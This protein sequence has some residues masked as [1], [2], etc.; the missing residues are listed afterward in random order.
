M[1]T[2]VKLLLIGL[3]YQCTSLSAEAIRLTLVQIFLQR[4]GIRLNPI[5]TMYHISPVCLMCLLIPFA[6]LEAEKLA[7]HDWQIAPGLLILSCVAACSLNCAVFLLVGKTSA[8]TLNVAGVVKDVLLI[9][10]SVSIFG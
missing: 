1:D 8:L 4:K 10:L 7:T 9:Y 5:T 6:I 2:S 3:L